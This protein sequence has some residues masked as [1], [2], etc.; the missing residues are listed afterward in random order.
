MSRSPEEIRNEMKGLHLELVESV[1]AHKFQALRKDESL[2]NKIQ[3]FSGAFYEGEFVHAAK[4]AADLAYALRADGH[5]SADFNF[6]RHFEEYKSQ[7]NTIVMPPEWGF[8]EDSFDG[9][10]H[11]RSIELERGLCYTIGARPGTGKSTIGGNLMFYWGFLKQNYRVLYLTNEMKPG[12]MWIKLRQ[13][14][15]NLDQS[16]RI[17]FM[18]AKDWLRYPDKY[19][20]A[21]DKMVAMAKS[22][23]NIQIA[24][25]KGM[26]APE[27]VLTI[28][29]AR[30]RWGGLPP[31]AV[32]IDYLQN[33]PR[34]KVFRGDA[35]LGTMETMQMFSDQAAED[36]SVV[37]PISQMN[38]DGGFK[39]SEAPQEQSGI[40]WEVSRPELK[41]GTKM[42]QIDWKIIKSRITAY[43]TVRSRYD[44][45]SGTVLY[46]NL[47]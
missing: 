37:F 25:I 39:E 27:I 28:K 45:V 6:M 24:S 46:D 17:P 14:Q 42:A 40:A 19:N 29:K 9:V 33:V 35:R 30:E 34:D 32:F 5:S 8:R 13:I 10:M 18:V 2:H 4:L 43:F 31:D 11:D 23:P 1:K 7:G 21:Y 12:Q 22:M 26:Y 41:D 3:E 44:D 16:K 36:D 47:K 38:K 15:V 20:F